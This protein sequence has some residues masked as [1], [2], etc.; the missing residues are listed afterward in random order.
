VP[1]SLLRAADE[2]WLAFSTR[3]ILPVTLL[4][5]KPVGSGKPGPLFVR[6]HDAFE[7]YVRQIAGTPVL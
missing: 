6:M 7:A 1:E 3:G 2:I 5:G 4:D